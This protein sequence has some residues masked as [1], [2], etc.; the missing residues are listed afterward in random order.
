MGVSENSPNIV[1]ADWVMQ[2]LNVSRQ[3]VYK[4]MFNWWKS[5]Q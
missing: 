3:T 1:D 5:Q 2:E 4:W